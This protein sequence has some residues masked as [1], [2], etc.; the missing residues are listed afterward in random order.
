MATAGVTPTTDRVANDLLVTPRGLVVA[1]SEACDVSKDGVHFAR[2]KASSTTL[3]IS[4]FGG[5]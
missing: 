2:W 4:R 3:T 1:A 5:H